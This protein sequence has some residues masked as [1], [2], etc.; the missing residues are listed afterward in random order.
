[1][2]LLLSVWCLGVVL[3][4]NMS[5]KE[6]SRLLKGHVPAAA[7]TTNTTNTTATAA[8]AAASTQAAAATAAAQA[9]RDIAV[10][11][12]LDS[13]TTTPKPKTGQTWPSSSPPS[14]PSTP[15]PSSSSS[16]SLSSSLPSSS[17]SSSSSAAAAAAESPLGVASLPGTPGSGSRYVLSDLDLLSLANISPGSRLMWV[18]LA[19]VY[20][21]TAVTLM[22]GAN[23]TSFKVAHAGCDE[24]QWMG[25]VSMVLWRQSREAVALRVLYVT[26]SAPGD[27]SHTVLLRDIPGSWGFG[28]LEYGTFQHSVRHWLASSV[29]V[30]FLPR[31][32]R[33]VLGAAALRLV[34]SSQ[35]SITAASNL[36]TSGG[37][38]G[39]GDGVSVAEPG[40][41]DGGGTAYDRGAPPAFIVKEMAEVFPPC[42][43]VALH[44]VRDERSLAGL[45]QQ[46]S[47]T[48]RSLEDLIDFY[49]AR[50][51]AGRRVR[52][53]QVR[54]LGPLLGQWGV[55][56]YGV[57]PIRVDELLH[58]RTRLEVLY[59][60]LRAGLAKV[61]E[62]PRRWDAAV[63]STALH[64][65]DEAL[66]RPTPAPHPGELLW[67]NLRLRL[68]QISWRTA[69][70]RTAF[71][72]LLLSYTVPVSALQGLM[73]LRRLER[74]PVVKVIVRL[75]V[76]RSLLSGLLPGAVLRLFLMLLPA[77]L[78]RLVRWAGAISLSE[79]DFRTTTLA[80]DFQVVAVFLASLL[81]GAL[82]NQITEFVAQP[83]QVLTVLGT[84]VPQTASFFI[85]Y[86]LFNGL[87]VGPLGFLRP[88]ALL[89]LA[90]RNRLVTTPRA[91]AR[92][93]EAPEARFAHSV[94][95]HSLMIL[96]GLS[97]S[98]V[99]PLIAPACVVYFAMV[100]LMER[101]QHCYCW[102]RP[103]ESGGKMW[104]QVFRHVMVGLYTFHVVMLA[105]LVIK[106]FPFAPLVLPAP[107]GAAAFHRQLHSLYRR[108]W[109]NL[110]LRDA[111]D[112]DAMDEQEQDRLYGRNGS[113]RSG[114]G[115]G[116]VQGATRWVDGGPGSTDAVLVYGDDDDDGRNWEGECLAAAAA[117]AAAGSRSGGAAE[118]AP[119]PSGS[120][121]AAVRL[122]RQC[123]AAKDVGSGGGAS[124]GRSD[125]LGL[126]G[127]SSSAAGVRL[128]KLE[129]IIGM[130]RS[131]IQ[132][133][134][135]CSST[136]ASLLLFRRLYTYL[137]NITDDFFLL[138]FRT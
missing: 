105:L 47:T 69:V 103:Y 134:V 5:G 48:K 137:Y 29:L 120:H 70:A 23:V 90:L 93:W 100:G 24:V 2:F 132:A 61:D 49:A 8:A 53:R 22:V 60:Q 76:V 43:L 101:Y 112:L 115:G 97:Y 129:D 73:Q 75:S 42:R 84:G 54:V 40:D 77:L 80:F 126:L 68:W 116:A 96:L 122:P 127:H 15:S 89:T 10:A 111:A 1:M 65:R 36:A 30:R 119:A 55:D 138:S 17:S 44:V 78:S 113:G 20:V 59:E 6:V 41:D 121:A 46:Y 16:S 106:K 71:M 88:F 34:R 110:S 45:V 85:A 33:R 19:S 108:P 11:S 114:G 83:G 117:A 133:Y 99:N 118:E 57:R 13:F 109:S 56:L 102:S 124:A 104:S 79:V 128:M 67:G 72:A 81:A 9:A 39:G 51:A 98:L 38:G 27:S 107:L 64:D 12:V 18:H 125:L 136:Y 32:L 26:H 14:S 35:N 28:G 87:V 31:R 25:V 82:L 37:G 52:R 94:P 95:H 131:C 123:G 74:L 50:L 135:T 62:L 58:L 130:D 4:V 21:V 7:D 3:P 63:V 86:I 91:R 92:L 66:W